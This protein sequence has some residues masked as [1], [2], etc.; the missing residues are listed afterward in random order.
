MKNKILLSMNIILLPL[1]FLGHNY[2]STN[3]SSVTANYFVLAG[4]LAMIII[5][6]VSDSGKK[7]FKFFKASSAELKKIT[8]ANK[9][10][11][12]DK[13]IKILA[14]IIVSGVLIALSDNLISSFINHSLLT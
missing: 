11:T 6:A 13:M 9:N 14:I 12:L 1:L 3:M 7:Q 2:I 10:D 5:F 4:L 8:W